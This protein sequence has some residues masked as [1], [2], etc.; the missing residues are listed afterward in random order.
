MY[1]IPF[2]FHGA[3]T[4]ATSVWGKGVLLSFMEPMYVYYGHS[5]MVHYNCYNN[6]N[7]GHTASYFGQAYFN[8]AGIRSSEKRHL[9]WKACSTDRNTRTKFADPYNAKCT[10]RSEDPK[11]HGAATEQ[12]LKHDAIDNFDF[13]GFDVEGWAETP[14]KRPERN[15]PSRKISLWLA[16]RS[17][18]QCSGKVE[19]FVHKGAG[20]P[21][22]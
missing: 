22:I 5:G 17:F 20:T 11:P 15:A 14:D 1:S 2:V 10:M 4:A 3:G 12:G 16:V 19:Y 6:G 8:L 13:V 9:S 21:A 18:G 7:N